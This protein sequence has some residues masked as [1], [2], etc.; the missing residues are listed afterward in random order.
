MHIRTYMC[1][2]ELG[3]MKSH[4]RRG[5]GKSKPIQKQ[6][7]QNKKPITN[8]GWMGMKYGQKCGKVWKKIYEGIRSLVARAMGSMEEVKQYWTYNQGG[9][10]QSNK[11]F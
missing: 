9:W 4:C 10:K 11:S 2:H 3:E 6:Q 8:Q 7:Q 1:K 5:E